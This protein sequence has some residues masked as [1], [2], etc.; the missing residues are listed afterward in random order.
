[1]WACCA[2]TRWTTWPT[3]VIH[4]GADRVLLADHPEL[5]MYRTLP[6]ARVA[7]A[8][9]RRRKPYIFLVGGTPIGRDLAPR[10]AS[11]LRAG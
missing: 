5:A 7:I 6:Y 4:H 10:I 11:A 2:A 8:E 1:M 3:E 9:A